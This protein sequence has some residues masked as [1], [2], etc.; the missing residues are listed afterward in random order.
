VSVA[1]LLESLDAVSALRVSAMYAR[2]TSK[3]QGDLCPSNQGTASPDDPLIHLV[4]GG[5]SVYSRSDAGGQRV[6][7]LSRLNRNHSSVRQC[8]KEWLVEC[9]VHNLTGPLL[10]CQSFLSFHSCLSAI[11]SR[12]LSCLTGRDVDLPLTSPTPFVQHLA[13]VVTTSI[14]FA[15]SLLYSCSCTI[16][17]E[18]IVMQGACL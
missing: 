18:A 7:S 1:F 16:S 13:P 4:S 15:T 2:I 6:L 5:P 11:V 12:R 9:F 8:C 14:R 17:K 10:E 3:L